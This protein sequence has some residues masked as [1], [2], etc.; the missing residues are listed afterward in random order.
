MHLS[1]LDSYQEVWSANLLPDHQSTEKST[2]KVSSFVI[3]FKRMY[4]SFLKFRMTFALIKYLEKSPSH[5]REFPFA[6]R[7]CV[8]VES[9]VVCSPPPPPPFLLHHRLVVVDLH[10]ECKKMCRYRR[11]VF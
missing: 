10:K 5:N 4:I 6:A 8:T 11:S 1:D 7:K 3:G 9:C 2:T